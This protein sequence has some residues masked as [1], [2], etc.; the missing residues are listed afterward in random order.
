HLSLHS[1][2]TRRS[3]DLDRKC[4]SD[5][6]VDLHLVNPGHLIFDRFFHRDN[7]AVR[8]ID[9]VEAGVKGAGF[10]RPSRAGYEQ[11]SIGRTE[12]AFRSEEHT[13]ELQSLAYL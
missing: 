13:S 12:Q 10:A 1:F 9:V 11:N 4:H 2:P 5:I 8:L 6:V 3:S 7:L